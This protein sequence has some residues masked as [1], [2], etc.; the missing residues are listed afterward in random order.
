[1]EIYNRMAGVDEA[2][3]TESLDFIPSDDDVMGRVVNMYEFQSQQKG[4]E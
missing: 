1:M 4:Q 2:G 3:A